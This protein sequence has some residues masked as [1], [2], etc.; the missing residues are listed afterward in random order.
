MRRHTP[1]IWGQQVPPSASELPF[2]GSEI[3]RVILMKGTASLHPHK[4]NKVTRFVFTYSRNRGGG[5]M[6]WWKGSPLSKITSKQEMER[7]VASTY[8]L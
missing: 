8:Y 1:L 2:W 3:S 6:S 5:T 7:R 4:G